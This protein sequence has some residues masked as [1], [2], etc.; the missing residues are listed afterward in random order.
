MTPSPSQQHAIDAKLNF[1]LG[2]EVFDRLFLGFECGP[3]DNKTV[4]VFADNA[5]KA[6][7]IA[8]EYSWHI[9]VIVE[10]VMK[11]PVKSVYVASRDG[12]YP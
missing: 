10:S 7:I 11:T 5:E 9:A 4:R 1:M 12:L 8:S 3:V 6:A 2:A